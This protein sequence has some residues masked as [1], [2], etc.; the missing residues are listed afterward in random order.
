[1]DLLQVRVRWESSGLVAR[2]DELLIDNNI[3]L[4]R[5]AGSNVNW[6]AA[7]SLDP[8][9]HTEGFR[10]VVSGRAVMN[11]DSHDRCLVGGNRAEPQASSLPSR[12]AKFQF[13]SSLRRRCLSQ[14]NPGVLRHDAGLPLRE[15][16]MNSLMYRRG[17]PVSKARPNSATLSPI[18]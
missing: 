7:A 9:L 1:L 5:L 14:T 2:V 17:S 10:F 11:F 13:S 16:F 6:P 3:E 4:A 8:S 18:D 15:R 12:D